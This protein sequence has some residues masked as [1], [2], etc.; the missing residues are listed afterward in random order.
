[1]YLYKFLKFV[2]DTLGKNWG[3]IKKLCGAKS[4]YIY[5]YIYILYQS[6]SINYNNTHF[7]ESSRLYS[8]CS[9]QPPSTQSEFRGLVLA[10]RLVSPYQFE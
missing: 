6:G 7:L 1:M 2:L 5:I 3:V 4:I 8:I 9:Q 10:K